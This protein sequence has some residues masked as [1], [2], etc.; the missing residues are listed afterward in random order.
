MEA[1]Q[2]ETRMSAKKKKKISLA[3]AK[4][5]CPF[6][7]G[8]NEKIEV[9]KARL[10]YGLELYHPGDNQI[11]MHPNDKRGAESTPEIIECEDTLDDLD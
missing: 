6:P 3:Q 1:D 7:P 4:R 10:E 9:M 11:P 8:S 2:K 5:H